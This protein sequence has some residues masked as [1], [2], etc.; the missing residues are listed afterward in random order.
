VLAGGLTAGVAVEAVGKEALSNTVGEGLGEMLT[1]RDEIVP[2]VAPGALNEPP[3]GVPTRKDPAATT[4]TVM[5]IHPTRGKR[6]P[7]IRPTGAIG[8]EY[9]SSGRSS[10]AFIS[11]AT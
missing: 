8:V 10:S 4:I 9:W 1:S 7:E 3:P 11:A 6:R 2:D 5:A